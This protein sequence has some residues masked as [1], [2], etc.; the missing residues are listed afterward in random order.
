[1]KYFILLCDGMS[2]LPI[3]GL[4]DKTPMEAAATPFMD[5][6]AR[7]GYTGMLKTVPDSVFPGSDTANMSIMGYDPEKYYTGRA[8][9]EAI[10]IG[11]DLQPGDIAFRTNLVTLSDDE[12]YENKV[13]IDYSSDEITTAEAKEIISSIN[14]NFENDQLRFYPGKSYRHCMVWKNASIRGDLTPPHDILLRK[15]DKYLPADAYHKNIKEMMIKSSAILKNH[16]VNIQRAKNGLNPANSIWIWGQGTKPSFPKLTEK[17]NLKGSVITAVD[18]IFGLG[19][20]AGLDVVE[21]EGATGNIHTNFAGKAAAAI[22]EFEKGQDYIYLHVEAPDECGHRNELSNKIHSIELIDEKILATV[23][24]Y[25]I[26]NKSETGEDFRILVTPDHPTP[27]SLRTHTNDPVPFIIYSS[28]GLLYN[29]SP[30]YS[31]KDC[32]KSGV[33]IDKGFTLFESLIYK[34]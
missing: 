7:S 28:D 34:K 1:M 8:P 32:R 3:D 13:M 22:S 21:V 16:P 18:L 30:A 20:C 11:I 33:Y 2:D 5:M 19:I 29:P 31:E 14:G 15:I 6:L 9:I 23:Y 24:D 17:Y 10:S 26:K 27:I 25:L 4:N 12:P